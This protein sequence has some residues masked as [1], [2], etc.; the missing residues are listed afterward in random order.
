MVQHHAADQLHIE[1]A[2]VDEAASGFA[3]GG[4]RG[5]QKVVERGAVRQLLA[6]GRGLPGQFLIAQRLHLRLQSVDGFDDRHHRLHVARVLGAKHLG[7]EGL[8]PHVKN[9]QGKGDNNHAYNDKRCQ[10]LLLSFGLIV[11]LLPSGPRG[12]REIQQRN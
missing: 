8:R 4:E 3:H 9:H 7:E 5:N 10:H 1:V 6:E 11:I 2:H 12:R